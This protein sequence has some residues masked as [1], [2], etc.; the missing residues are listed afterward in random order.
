M[1]EQHGEACAKTH[2]TPSLPAKRHDFADLESFKLRAKDSIEL[3]MSVDSDMNPFRDKPVLNEIMADIRRAS[4]LDELRKTI[5]ECLDAVKN[6][7]ATYVE[8]NRVIEEMQGEL[9]WKKH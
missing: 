6:V 3:L 1:T 7:V 8:L 2:Q 5:N 9:V 4:S